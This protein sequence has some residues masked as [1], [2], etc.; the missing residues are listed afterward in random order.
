M[1]NLY[2]YLRFCGNIMCTAGLNEI[3]WLQVA[4]GM[5]ANGFGMLNDG[6]F[7]LF[8]AIR[9][10]VGPHGGNMKTWRLLLAAH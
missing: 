3:F 5:D 2:N 9:G 8:W 6:N 10:A 4:T 7:A 1:A